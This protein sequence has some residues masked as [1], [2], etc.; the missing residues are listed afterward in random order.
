MTLESIAPDLWTLEGDRVRMLGI[1]FATRMAVVRLRSGDLWL[2]NPVQPTEARVT[3]VA[4]LGPIAHL[5][6]PTAFHNLFLAPWRERAPDA[7]VWGEAKNV[8]RKPELGFDHTLEDEPPA[9]WRE[10]VDQ[11]WLRGSSVMDE[12]VFLHRASRTALFTDVVQNHDPA[13]DGAFFRTAKRIN[14]I[15]A[16]ATSAPRDWRLTVRDKE[17]LRRGVER[18]LAWDFDRVIVSHGLNVETGGKAFVERVFSWL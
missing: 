9:A 14:G 6:G 2:W 7:Q 8:A 4:A 18:V 11:V 12:V 1:P 5:V 16:P 10:A 3:D 13:A 15:L 17:T